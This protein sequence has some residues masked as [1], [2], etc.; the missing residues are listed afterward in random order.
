MRFAFVGLLLLSSFAVHAQ[1]A[2]C[3]TP[4]E[5]KLQPMIAVAAAAADEGGCPN[6]AK[7]KNLCTMVSGRMKDSSGKNKYL[8]QTRFQESACI[9][10]SD[11]EEVKAQKIKE[12]WSKYEDDLKCNSTQ[13]DV[14]DGSLIKY[15]VSYR[16]DEF[17]DEVIKW[18]IN[19]NK[20]DAT[21]GRTP[22]DYIK[23]HIEKNKGNAL[24]GKFQIYYDKLKAAGAKH[25]SEL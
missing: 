6:R 3:A 2:D 17:I 11:S 10:S 19:L 16:F 4:T 1:E 18:K 7:L 5:E 13:F 9:Q 25:K 23:Y 8:Y 20:V 14:M 24:E 21:D 15:S 22:L 12:A